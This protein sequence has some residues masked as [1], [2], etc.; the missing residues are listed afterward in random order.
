MSHVASVECLVRD[1]DALAAAAERCGL[2][3]IEGQTHHRWFGRWLNDWHSPRAAVSKGHD[4]STF[5]TC[6]HALKLANGLSTDYE[7]GVVAREDGDGYHL[8]Y[9]SYGPGHKL[10]AAAGVDL[11]TLQNEVLAEV[12]QRSL[13]MGGYRVQRDTEAPAGQIRLLAYA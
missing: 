4:P 7:I 6:A 12:A 9:D 2:I 5:G 10:E 3:F 1:L 13:A 11:V 8:V